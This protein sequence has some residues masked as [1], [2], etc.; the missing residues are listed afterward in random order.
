MVLSFSCSS[1]SL[2]MT[3]EG[4]KLISSAMVAALPGS[5]PPYV[6]NIACKPC[7]ALLL[8]SALMAGNHEA[9]LSYNQCNKYS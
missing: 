3:K 8:M 6:K 4:V 2:G 1:S 9:Q 5:M 7:H